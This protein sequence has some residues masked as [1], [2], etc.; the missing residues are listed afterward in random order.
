[1]F[2]VTL[3]KKCMVGS[4][5]S[6]MFLYWQQQQKKVGT[7][8]ERKSW[9]SYSWSETETILTEG[10]EPETDFRVKEKH[11]ALGLWME[12]KNPGPMWCAYNVAYTSNNPFY[13]FY[14]TFLMRNPQTFFSSR[15]CSEYKDH[16]TLGTVLSPSR[17]YLT[18]KG[19]WLKLSLYTAMRSLYLSF[20]GPVVRW[21]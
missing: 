18:V 13:D 7:L 4:W 8:Q 6:A 2:H 12:S 19:L 17:I 14:T 16:S 11:C 10:W 1:M 15:F 9:S 5:K 21:D 20:R 3:I